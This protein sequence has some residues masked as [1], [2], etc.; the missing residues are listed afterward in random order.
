[1]PGAFSLPDAAQSGKAPFSS[2]RADT[3]KDKTK[4]GQSVLTAQSILLSLEY[5]CSCETRLRDGNRWDP[6]GLPD[7]IRRKGC[8]NCVWFWRRRGGTWLRGW[9]WRAGHDAEHKAVQRPNQCFSLDEY[10]SSKGYGGMHEGSTLGPFLRS[11][12]T[13]IKC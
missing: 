7:S 3:L 2:C 8:A 13:E 5:G 1:M 6:S 4:M 12:G 9:I 10:S 11:K